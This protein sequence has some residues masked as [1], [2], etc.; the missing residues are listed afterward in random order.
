[1]ISLD[2]RAVGDASYA[3]AED[4]TLVVRLCSW[5]SPYSL[6]GARNRHPR[7]GSFDVLH[8]IPD[9]AG[10]EVIRVVAERR[11]RRFKIVIA[12][13]QWHI[14]LRVL[15]SDWWQGCLLRGPA[16]GSMIFD[17][18]VRS[19]RGGRSAGRVLG[20]PPSYQHSFPSAHRTVAGVLRFS[21]TDTGSQIRAIDRAIRRRGS[22]C[23]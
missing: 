14:A 21:D 10:D 15:A 19:H 9:L 18:W 6:W 17:D 22:G 1:M 12:N 2:G 23:P 13:E 3:S 4:T 20:L 8:L 5:E 7:R 11:P 16:Y